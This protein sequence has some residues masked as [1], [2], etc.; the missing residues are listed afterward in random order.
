MRIH[1]ALHTTL[2]E[3]NISGQMVANEAGISGS[4][5]SQFRRGKKRMTDEVLD[6]LLTGMEKIAPGSKRYFCN[7][8]ADSSVSEKG[9]LLSLVDD[10][11]EEDIPRLLIA[12]AFGTPLA[13]IARRWNGSVE[14]IG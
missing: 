13:E 5:V 14:L 8:L 3:Y 7:L 9:I 6:K 1:E 2:E 10:I 11:P 12:I 4:M